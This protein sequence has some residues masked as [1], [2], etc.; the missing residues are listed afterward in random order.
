MTNSIEVWRKG[1]DRAMAQIYSPELLALSQFLYDRKETL[2]TDGVEPPTADP[3]KQPELY[4]LQLQQF[5][6]LAWDFRGGKERWHAAKF[7]FSPEAIAATVATS[8]ALGLVDTTSPVYEEYEMAFVLGAGGFIAS[9]RAENVASHVY[10]TKIPK[11]SV[12]HIIHTGSERPLADWSADEVVSFA[13]DPARK[14]ASQRRITE[15][16]AMYLAAV[17]QH[18]LDPD[19][20]EDIE[21]SHSSSVFTKWRVRRMEPVHSDQPMITILGAPSLDVGRRA[22]TPHTYRFL[23]EIGLVPSNGR[24]LASTNARF[25]LFQS[26]DAVR[27]FGIPNNIDIDT[28]VYGPG[29]EISNL[30]PDAYGDWVVGLEEGELRDTQM[31]T[32][33]D[34]LQ[35]MHSG[36]N[37]GLRLMKV[38]K[39]ELV[40]PQGLMTSY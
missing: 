10:G 8:H 5:T 20:Y 17:K 1:A 6:Q 35:E 9:E 27:D 14:I 21:W 16:D 7:E 32:V 39:P 34:L 29:K 40:V 12:G 19:A 3:S 18:D 23:S 31:G 37:S 13:G 24:L 25:R 22:T 38:I 30:S 15:F 26:I 11:I 33:R 2:P 36:V 28:M 4:L